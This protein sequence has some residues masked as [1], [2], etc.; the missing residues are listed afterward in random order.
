[1]GCCR[2]EIGQ[3]SARLRPQD[4]PQTMKPRREVPCR[5]HSQPNCPR[6]VRPFFM[7]SLSPYM[8][9]PAHHAEAPNGGLHP[10]HVH[11]GSRPMHVQARTIPATCSRSSAIWK[12]RP[13]P[14]PLSRRPPSCLARLSDRRTVQRSRMLHG[15]GA[16]Y[17]MCTNTWPL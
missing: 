15:K 3:M 16:P 6:M 14:S 2:A 13:L 4:T 9:M 8:Q 17:T 5:I 1:M 11:I 7:H 10:S 12:T